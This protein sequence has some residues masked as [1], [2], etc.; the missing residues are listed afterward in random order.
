MLVFRHA[1]RAKVYVQTK[2]TPM[3]GS[4]DWGLVAPVTNDAG[5]HVVGG[6]RL[7]AHNIE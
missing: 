6:V 2:Q 3:A 5:M 7:D 1:F 4:R